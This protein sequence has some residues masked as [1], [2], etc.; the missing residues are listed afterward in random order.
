MRTYT[1]LDQFINSLKD[2]ELRLYEMYYTFAIQLGKSE[3]EAKV[4]SAESVFNARKMLR[5]KSILKY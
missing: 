1:N 3:Y 5:D 4:D 2:H